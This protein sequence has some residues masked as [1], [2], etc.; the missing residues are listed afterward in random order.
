MTTTTTSDYLGILAARDDF[1]PMLIEALRT[2]RFPVAYATL[3]A[4]QSH[5]MQ[6]CIVDKVLNDGWNDRDIR[7]HLITNCQ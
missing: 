5:A 1:H 3:L 4:H 2:C 7:A 6:A